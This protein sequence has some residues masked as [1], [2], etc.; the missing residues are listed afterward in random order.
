MK[1]ELAYRP[2]DWAMIRSPLLPANVE[3]ASK[4]PFS[5]GSLL[6]DDAR[7]RLAVLVASRDLTDALER[8]SPHDRAAARVRGKLVRYLIRMSTRP[9]PFGLFAGVGLVHWA[10]ATD[11]ALAATPM[12]T[13]T[14]P[15]MEWLSNLVMCLEQDP[16]I[17]AELRLVTNPATCLRSGRMWLTDGLAA[18]ASVRATAA[19]CLVLEAARSP[20]TAGRLADV[21]CQVPGASPGKARLL[22]D[23][24]RSEGFLLSELRP[25][26][27]GCDPTSHVWRCLEGVAGGKDVAEKLKAL[28]EDLASWDRLPVKDR[29][30]PW[31]GLL[32]RANELQAVPER[33]GPYQTDAALTL[34][35]NSLRATVG[36]EAAR[37]AEL[38]L[39]LSPYPAGNPLLEGYR[40][41]FQAK[42]SPGCQVPL[43]ELLDPETGLGSLSEYHADGAATQ[44]PPRRSRLLLDLALRAN[45]DNQAIV[46]LTDEHINDLA[47]SPAASDDYPLSLELSLFIAAASPA[48]LD[49]GDFQLVIGPNVGAAEA[50][51]HLGRFADL[52]G[53]SAHRALEETVRAEAE[54]APHTLPV[55]VV[56]QPA[57][58]R[59]ANVAIRPTLR[60]HEC[61]F[62]TLPGVPWEHVVP[63]SELV[64][65][66]R[67]GRFVVSWPAVGT[68]VVAV[69]GHMLNPVTAPPAA[70]FLLAAAT[71]GQRQV[72]PFSWGPAASFL[73]LPRV[74][75]GRIVLS[76]AQWRIDPAG[77]LG[78]ASPDGFPVAV[79]AWRA[80]WAVPRYVYLAMG[81]NRLLLDLEQGHHLDVLREELHSIADG[82]SA[83][84]QEG[85]PGPEH[86]WLPGETGGHI[87]EIVVPLVRRRQAACRTA[88]SVQPPHTVWTPARAQ[89]RP[90]GSD[91]LYLK[92][93]G[94]Q[95]LQNE[96]ISGPLRSFGEFVMTAGLSDGWFFV[97]YADPED[98]LRIRYHGDPAMLLGPLLG[99]A[100]SW[101]A[102]LLHDSMCTRFS[103]ET[104]EPE[105]DRYGGEEG[106]R[107][108][109]MVFMAESPITASMLHATNEGQLS[110]D[111]LTLAVISVD[112]L[113]ESISMTG[114][115]RREF[116]R[117]AAAPSQA[118]G[119]IFRER[120]FDLR[121]ILGCRGQLE[122]AAARLLD[123]RRKTLA[124]AVSLLDSLANRNHLNRTWTELCQ[125]YIHMHLN[126]LLGGDRTQEHITLDL[127]RRTHESLARCPLTTEARRFRR[128]V[129]RPTDRPGG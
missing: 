87:S 37:A 97:R 92:L 88:P 13:R 64:V 95:G 68:D 11:L 108:A 115:Q 119:N 75:R 84:L 112:D 24:L 118:G 76:P 67:S 57:A 96:I 117:E 54:L 7:A 12:R 90:P 124:P 4:P 56:Y 80:D 61:V 17:R 5:N 46:E 36:T 33:G 28:A 113:L 81:D 106:I 27:T 103:F 60:T 128:P 51:R 31:P 43:P 69:Q 26:L 55:E 86:A 58:A 93:Y 70:R 49:T 65:S 66:V 48:A 100:C 126:R 45:R 121:Q 44:T 72:S 38:L 114:D 23:R 19:V 94:N 34:Q 15:D 122:P 73:F 120:Q 1:K 21:A 101:A 102:D 40:R 62:G 63:L 8:T 125:S 59:S 20:A 83:L 79:A 35:G 116:F 74:Q 10:E 2:L 52:L 50:G 41:A 32:Q 30:H 82:R 42:Y 105:V 6:P 127:L 16:A 3:A 77:P 14:R 89:L 104:Y 123:A 129:S 29:V 85:L 91:W 9:T 109:E 53:P 107:A 98:H 22:V 25:P 99:Q 111:L 71:D 18:E 39:R 78:R 47:I 110:T